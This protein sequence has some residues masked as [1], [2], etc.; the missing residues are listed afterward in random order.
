MR[1]ISFLGR[2]WSFPV[3]FLDTGTKMSEFEEDIHESLRILL[4]TYPG[5]RTMRPDFGCRLRDYCFESYSLRLITLIQ[6]EVRRAIL[7]NEPRVDVENV[8]VMESE[9]KEV[10]KVEVVYVV[11]STNSRMNLVFPFYLNEATDASI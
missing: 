7:M 8:N 4:M 3:M 1:D 6:S 9:K 11:R 2:G 5:G 10:L